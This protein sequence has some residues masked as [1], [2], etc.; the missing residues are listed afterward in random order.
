MDDDTT[1]AYSVISAITAE[2]NAL[3]TQ[4][5]ELQAENFRL[6]SQ[7]IRETAMATAAYAD[8]QRAED[9][10]VVLHTA[11]SEM[12]CTCL[13]HALPGDGMCSRCLALKGHLHA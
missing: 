1:A 8:A 5:S 13:P 9:R 7:I 11:L 3:R 2:R 12:Q 4:L 10:V 6:Q